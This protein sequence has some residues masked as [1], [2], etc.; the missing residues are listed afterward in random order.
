MY[1]CR[2]HASSV[3]AT[4][5]SIAAPTP[6]FNWTGQ[7]SVAKT[8]QRTKLRKSEFV[9]VQQAW[10]VKVKLFDELLDAYNA[11]MR[12]TKKNKRV[13]MKLWVIPRSVQ[14]RWTQDELKRVKKMQQ[15]SRK[16]LV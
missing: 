6:N 16:C 7:A 2:S 12:T 9:L 15:M 5:S 8:T 14:R 11:A 3:Q 1:N 13:P 10:A 4:P